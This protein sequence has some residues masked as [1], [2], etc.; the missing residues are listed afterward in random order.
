MMGHTPPGK[1]YLFINLFGG[2]GWSTTP[3][4]C[5]KNIPSSLSNLFID[6]KKVL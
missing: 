1:M 4:V 3:M 2:E 5:S 6:S